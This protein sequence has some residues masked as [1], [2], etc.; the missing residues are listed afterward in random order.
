M[1][2]CNL[3]VRRRGP[4]NTLGQGVCVPG[5]SASSVALPARTPLLWPPPFPRGRHFHF[6]KVHWQGTT[7]SYFLNSGQQVAVFLGQGSPFPGD[8]SSLLLPA[9][10]RT[11]DVPSVL[12]HLQGL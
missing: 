3:A 12:S 2:L 10:P 6:C 7:A 11:G 4:G 8:T 5:V 9:S 1:Q